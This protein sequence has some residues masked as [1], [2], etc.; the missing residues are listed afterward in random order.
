M[1]TP[2]VKLT[3][4]RILP[5]GIIWL[6]FGLIYLL[7][8]RG[9]IGDLDYYPATGNP[10]NFNSN[11]LVSLVIVFVGGLAVGAFEVLF[12]RKRFMRHSFA[13]K[14]FYKASIYVVIIVSFLSLVTLIV[15]AIEL[16][17][18]IFDPSIWALLG[19]FFSNFAFWS[20][21]LYIAALMTVVLFYSEMS[22]NVG[23]HVLHNFF[24]GKYHKPVEE[25]RIFMFLDMNASTTIA[26]KLGHIKYFKLLKKYYTDLSESVI[27]YSGEIYQYVGDELVVSWSVNNGLYNNGCLQ[28]F[29]SMQKALQSQSENYLSEFDVLPT[30]KAGLHI[31]H[32]TTGE[33][34]EIKKDII[35][36]GDVLNTTARIQGLCKTFQVK[37]LLSEPLLQRM[38]LGPE[39]SVRPLGEQTLRGRKGGMKVSTV[40]KSIIA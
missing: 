26:E 36:T 35:F 19:I 20:I 30:F 39:W 10:Y 31:G 32:V 33:I 1:L 3:I 2:K 6:V 4:Y 17:T 40:E 23:I 15:N 18:S 12:L 21:T 8:E 11:T 34:G 13:R 38:K 7:M 29:F 28:C 14:I 9:I 5:F 25:E 27:D 22:E 37:I 24:L 16:Q